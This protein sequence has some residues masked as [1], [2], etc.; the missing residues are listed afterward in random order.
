VNDDFMW[1]EVS[2]VIR[3]T[4]RPVWGHDHGHHNGHGDYDDHGDHG[5][6]DYHPSYGD[7]HDDHH[8]NNH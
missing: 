2:Q 6:H 5:N 7:R 3:V 1:P 8:S 4:I